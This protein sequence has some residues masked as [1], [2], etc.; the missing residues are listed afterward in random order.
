MNTIISYCGLICEV[1][2]IYLFTREE[3]KTKKDKMIHEVL[4]ACKEHYEIEYSYE[5]INDC[6]GCKSESGKL[7]F[8]CSSCKIRKCAIE[9]GIENC[10]Y[11]D[12]YACNNLME[13]FKTDPSAK[14]RL[15]GI[16]N[17]I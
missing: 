15:D 5:D 1:C 11:C 7:F 3:N 13:L 4:T 16:R 17:N 14:T 2:P 12:K 6:D 9:N 10:A 8:G